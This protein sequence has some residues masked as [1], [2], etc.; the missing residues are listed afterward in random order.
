MSS[1]MLRS[2]A[3]VRTDLSEEQFPLYHQ[4][5][6]IKGAGNNV[7]LTSNQRTL[8]RLLVMANVVPSS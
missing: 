1:W 2:V 5:E 7:D 6:K 4:D 8:R 3:L